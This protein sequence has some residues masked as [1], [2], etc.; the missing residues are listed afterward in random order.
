MGAVVLAAGVA[1]VVA[2]PD[3]LDPASPPDEA[4]PDAAAIAEDEEPAGPAS[5]PAP[6]AIPE[7]PT[8]PRLPVQPT[9]QRQPE[10]ATLDAVSLDGLPF[11]AECGL[12]L[13]PVGEPEVIFASGVSRDPA[14]G[15]PAAAMVDGELVLLRRVGADG[16]PLG[17]N[18]FPRQLFRDE[19][20]R[21]TVV[22]EIALEEEPLDDSARVSEGTL[23]VMKAE[24]A[25]ARLAIAGRAGC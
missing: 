18:Q 9:V 12:Q 13:R 19:A 25:T 24:R 2:V 16:D 7:P 4:A 6:L 23:T 21:V 3:A 14:A 8:L 15:G 11:N 1:Y 10:P 22:V 20:E 17:Y 5:E